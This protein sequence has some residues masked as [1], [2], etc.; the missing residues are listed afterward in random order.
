MMKNSKQ[1]NFKDC[2]KIY[3]DVFGFRCKFQIYFF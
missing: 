3:I 1:T 2:M